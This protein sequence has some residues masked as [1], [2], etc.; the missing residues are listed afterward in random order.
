MSRAS[1][2]TSSAA[3]R[4]TRAIAAQLSAAGTRADHSAAINA[5]FS[6]TTRGDAASHQQSRQL[7]DVDFFEAHGWVIVPSVVQA[8]AVEK[9]VGEIATLL[10]MDLSNPCDWYN[11]S[12]GAYGKAPLE[13]GAGMVEL[14]QSQGMW[15]NRTAP[16]VH[17][18]FSEV[19][20]SK[21]LLVTMDRCNF[22]PPAR[23]TDDPWSRGLPLHW[24]GP[25]PGEAGPFLEEL[26]VQGALLLSD[27]GPGRGG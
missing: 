25:R 27:V 11:D 15:N 19:L 13:I 23:S 17:Q 10:R 12:G 26:S 24:D 16:K 3:L 9:V 4:R 6:T 21:K 8:E 7:V 5:A 18:A 14:Y 22:K 20:G 1:S 2:G